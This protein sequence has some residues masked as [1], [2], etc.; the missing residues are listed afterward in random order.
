MFQREANRLLAVDC[1]RGD[2]DIRNRPQEL[3]PCLPDS[4]VSSTMSTVVVIASLG[5]RPEDAE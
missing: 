2:D 5:G 4:R 1:L 3:P